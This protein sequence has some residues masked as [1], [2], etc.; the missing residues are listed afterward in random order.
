M[1]LSRDLGA[2]V[3]RAVIDLRDPVRPSDERLLQ[4]VLDAAP[5][6]LVVLDHG[7]RVIGWNRA[8]EELLGWTREAIVGR[9][10]PLATGSLESDGVAG[11]RRELAFRGADGTVGHF[12]AEVYP[13][14]E[15]DGIGG[16]VI[17]LRSVRP[18]PSQALRTLESRVERIGRSVDDVIM[19]LDGD[20][21]I[22]GI[23]QHAEIVLGRARNW[24]IG[25]SVLDLLHPDDGSLALATLALLAECPNI[26]V[27]R[28]FRSLDRH[29]VTH[30]LE[31]T[32]IN[33]L[34]DPEIGA[35]VV[36][37]RNITA[38]RRAL[39]L[40]AGEAVVFERIATGE[41]L[42]STLAELT[43]LIET[44]VQ[45]ATAAVLVVD[46]DEIDVAG[47]LPAA[48]RAAIQGTTPAQWFGC[49]RGALL[50]AGPFTVTD[51]AGSELYAGHEGPFLDAG[52]RASTSIPIEE[53]DGRKP[54]AALVV[55]L[56]APRRPNRFERHVIEDAARLAAIALQRH[57]AERA[58]SHLAH[59]DKLTGLPNRALLQA[60]LET[61][62]RHAARHD[63]GVALMF[64]DLDDFKL[65]NDTLGHAAGDEVL[66][67]FAERLGR[68]LRPGDTVARF[69]G[70]EFV[71]LLENVQ[72]PDDATPV[73][74]RLLADL[75]RPF[76]IG[77]KEVF[78]TVSVG[79]AAT[80]T[81]GLD[82]D[83]LL[84]HADAAMYSAKGRGRA[85]IE[86]FD[87]SAPDRATARLQMEGDLNRALA[88][89]QLE[90]LWQPK[91]SLRTGR[92]VSAET[93]VRWR[94]P[95]HGLVLPEE[96]IPLAEDTGLITT[97]G[98]WVLSEALQQGQVVQRESGIGNWSIAVNLSA[99]Q[100]Q[101]PRFVGDVAA[102][103][104]Q[105]GW[106][107][108]RLVL[109]LTEGVLM[110]EA[111]DAPLHRLRQF[112]LQLAIDD[113]GT[114]YS[115]LSYLHRFPVGMVKLDRAFVHG[116]AADG[117]GSPIAR[118]VIQ[119]AHALG[120]TAT[121]EGVETADQL[122]GLRVL[123]C[124]WVQGYHLARPMPAAEFAALLGEQ[125]TFV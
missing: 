3:G 95:E 31:I 5:N 111:T 100:L 58:L 79:I 37:T 63:S 66:L 93:L 124:D 17:V 121:A 11:V 61:A 77:A 47:D 82:L 29:G 2:D 107:A 67:G 8:A 65:I 83:Q 49:W 22:L 110:D 41:A 53:P 115:S 86:V 69:G 72:G 51:L 94:H 123:G 34:D 43:Q 71:V 118:A 21:T 85:R 1:A 18:G 26:P 76:R 16:T 7:R 122:A 112:G 59:H 48:V 98:R 20:G 120:I 42:H 108:N 54:I 27:T 30:Y 116:I 15:D 92:I 55:W 75:Q 114:G 64:I 12:R 102:L 32:A 23:D 88:D 60:R 119:M 39:A 40:Q 103:L 89:D 105:H 68:L 80:H 24:W 81:T 4:T 10:V 57:Q 117:E 36:A 25:R 45:Q 74:E 33:L 96:F 73:A 78:L 99:R 13:L 87:R 44:H 28:E 113:F 9:P 46:G 50:G 101:A 97:L 104:R 84:R 90:L 109:E 52:L 62:L 125:R 56:T 91:I 19:V 106:P 6:A 35:L 14:P 70:D 38:R